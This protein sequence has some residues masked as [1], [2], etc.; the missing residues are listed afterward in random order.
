MIQFSFDRGE[1]GYCKV[2]KESKQ[3]T[4]QPNFFF[5][6]SFVFM[7]QKREISKESVK[8]RINL[9]KRKKSVKMRCLLF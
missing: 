2:D 7:K 3:E 8:M 4:S 1:G 5:K 9:K 6:F